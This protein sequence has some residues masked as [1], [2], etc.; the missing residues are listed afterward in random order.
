MEPFR[1]T[2]FFKHKSI[3]RCALIRHRTDIIMYRISRITKKNC[4]P[5]MMWQKKVMNEKLTV[6]LVGKNS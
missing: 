4:A 6:G 1:F 3:D 5:G 2:H